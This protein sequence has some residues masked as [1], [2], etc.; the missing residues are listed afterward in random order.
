MIGL[1]F[2]TFFG[3]PGSRYLG[4]PWTSDAFQPVAGPGAVA[5]ERGDDVNRSDGVRQAGQ[6]EACRHA[7]ADPI[8]IEFHVRA[9]FRFAVQ[10][11]LARRPPS[12]SRSLFPPS[13][14]TK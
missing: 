1:R 8:G 6:Q 9:R 10:M 12:T 2:A 11:E 13:D 7:A 4:S 14:K 5:F 3:L